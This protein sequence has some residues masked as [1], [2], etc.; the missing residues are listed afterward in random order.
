[1]NAALAVR[2]RLLFIAHFIYLFHFC[3]GGTCWSAMVRNGNGRCTELLHEKISKEDCCSG[4][5]VTT[6]WSSEEL[7]SGT[8]FFWRIL[9]GGVRCSS[10]R[11]SCKEVVCDVDKTC[12]LRKGTPKCVCASKCKEGKLRSLKGPVCGTDG[13]SYRNVCR[14]R[15]QSCRRR[16]NSLTIAYKGI[17][18]SSCDKIVCPSN[19][20]CLLDQNLTPHCVNCTKK[21]PNAPKRRQVC[22]S[23]GLTYTSACHLR[24]K[25]CRR[26]KAIPIAYKGTCRANATCKKVKCRDGQSCL[27]DLNSGMPRCVSCTTSCKPRHVM[28]GP[29]CGTNNSTYHTWCHMMQDACFKGYFIDTMYHGRCK[30]KTSQFNYYLKVYARYGLDMEINLFF[31]SYITSI[32]SIHKIR[33]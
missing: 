16:S 8:L 18:Q 2:L 19:K 14:L 12:V 20:H 5:S 23:D 26:G 9:G 11:D 7:D 27:K 33:G 3:L 24:E 17:C 29:I 13:R 21:C 25:A 1:M 15:K 30:V 28:R 4:R 31:P 32:R 22:G 10:C 6:S